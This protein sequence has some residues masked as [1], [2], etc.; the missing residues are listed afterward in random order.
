MADRGDLERG[1][2]HRGPVDDEGFR[3]CRASVSG[4]AVAAESFIDP[5]LRIQ[6][7]WNVNVVAQIVGERCLDLAPEYLDQ[8]RDYAAKGSELLR[9]SFRSS[10]YTVIPSQCHYFLVE[11][12]EADGFQRRLLRKGMAVRDCSSFG[13]PEYVRIAPRRMEENEALARGRCRFRGK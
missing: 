2:S 10:G 7:P 3:P 13:L 12:G 5:L 9:S 8:V 6:A 4:Y 11:V 1:Q